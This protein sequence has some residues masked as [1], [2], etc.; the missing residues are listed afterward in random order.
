MAFSHGIKPIVT[1]GLVTYLDA[2]NKRS[3]P[4]SGTAWN[5][6]A[7]SNNGT[8]TNG[9]TFDSSNLG[10]IDFDGVDDYVNVPYNSS[11]AFA[12]GDSIT[13]DLWTYLDNSAGSALISRGRDT[14]ITGNQPS[15]F[16]IE[17]NFTGNKIQFTYRVGPQ[18]WE[19]TNG[20]T[21]SNWYNIVITYTYGTGSSIKCYVNNNL[22]G[23]SWIDGTGNTS[24]TGNTQPMELAARKNS[25]D[26]TGDFYAG[27]IA[28]AAIY[29]RIL[30]ST[31]V[32][33][34]FNALKYRFG[35]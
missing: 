27:K 35:L 17:W 18:R 15:N 6:L 1:D 12:S 28:K 7:L 29:N 22:E 8:L 5:D 9:P 10:I 25:S 16:K 14:N 24:P 4:G 3:Y 23:G 33:Q 32:S 30:S 19:T 2:A 34:N 21:N 20:F 26:V 11:L 31:E 13:I